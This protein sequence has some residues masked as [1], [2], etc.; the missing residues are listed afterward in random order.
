MVCSV[1]GAPTLTTAIILPVMIYAGLTDLYW[2]LFILAVYLV[3]CGVPFF[4]IAIG[5]GEFLYRA[6]L[7]MRNALLVADAFLLIG[8][9]VLLILDPQTVANTL[10]APANLLLEPFRW[11]P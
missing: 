1:A 5:L 9:G 3:V 10:S 6:S 2:S 11:L 4:L 8:L 7:R